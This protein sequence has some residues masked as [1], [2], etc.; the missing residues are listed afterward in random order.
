MVPPVLEYTEVFSRGTGE[1]SDIVRKEMYTFNDKGDRSVTLRPE[2]TAGVVRSV[3]SNKL[4]ATEEM[5]LKL[6][7]CGPAF[8]YERPQLGRYRQFNQFGVEAIGQDSARLDAECIIMAVQ[9]L[10][11]LGFKKLSLKINTIGDDLP[12]QPYREALKTISPA[13]SMRCATIAMSGSN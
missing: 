8:R 13:I 3:V 6:Y 1:S 7:Y 9:G 10:S 5:P 2:F 11:M 4:Y 12:R